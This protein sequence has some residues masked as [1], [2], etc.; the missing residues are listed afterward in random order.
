M[1]GFDGVSIDSYR[2]LNSVTAVRY[3]EDIYPAFGKSAISV[4]ENISLA[5]TQQERWIFNHPVVKYDSYLLTEAI[6]QISRIESSASTEYIK[7]VFSEHALSKDGFRYNQ[8]TYRLLSDIDVLHDMKNHI[9]ISEIEQYFIRQSRFR[10]VW[11]SFAEYNVLFNVK[12]SRFTLDA[13]KKSFLYW[14]NYVDIHK[15]YQVNEEKYMQ[16]QTDISSGIAQPQ[17]LFLISYLRQFCFDKK[18]AFNLVILSANNP[19]ERF[20]SLGD[21]YLRFNGLDRFDSGC[22]PCKYSDVYMSQSNEPMQVEDNKF[23]YLYS[24]EYIDKNEIASFLTKQDFSLY[25]KR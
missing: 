7:N 18:I 16:L 3:E 14:F 23:F 11:K 8:R 22:E 5:K 25:I 1:S 21:I 6:F 24:K 4:L 19:G 2:L 17:S 15:T 20:S 10:P 13:F 12:R 9:D